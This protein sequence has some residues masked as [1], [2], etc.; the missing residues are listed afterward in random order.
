MA[1][2]SDDLLRLQEAYTS[3]AAASLQAVYAEN[4]KLQALTRR[5]LLHCLGF[6]QKEALQL[7]ERLSEKQDQIALLQE[8]PP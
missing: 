8:H 6:M 1:G 4:Q 3:A 2:S 5:W 7:Q